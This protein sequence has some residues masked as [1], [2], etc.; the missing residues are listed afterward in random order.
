V[1][2]RSVYGATASVFWVYERWS[3]STPDATVT[4]R[5][6]AA[7][8]LAA[9]TP[10]FVHRVDTW[11]PDA[12]EADW[13]A[14]SD[15]ATWTAAAADVSRTS[16]AAQV[17]AGPAQQFVVSPAAARLAA[18]DPAQ[19]ADAVTAAVGD[20]LGMSVDDVTARLAV[21]A[22]LADLA[23]EAGVPDPVLLDRIRAAL[24]DPGDDVLAAAVA[25]RVARH[26]GPLDAA[27]LQVSPMAGGEATQVLALT[28]DRTAALLRTTPSD[29]MGRLSGGASLAS[30]AQAR[31]LSQGA[32]LDAVRWDLPPQT[33]AWDDRL[34]LAA[35]VAGDAASVTEVPPQPV[36]GQLFAVASEAGPSS[37]TVSLDATAALLGTTTDDLMAQLSAGE[38]LGGLADAAGVTHDDLVDAV[39]TDLPARTEGWSDAAELAEQVIGSASSATVVPEAGAGAAGGGGAAP[40]QGRRFVVDVGTGPQPVETTLDATLSVLGTTLPELAALLDAG[41]SLDAVAQAAGLTHGDLLDAL[42]ADLPGQTPGW[43]DVYALAEQVAVTRASEPLTPPAPEN[44]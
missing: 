20:P 11:S 8:A 28:L 36:A 4:G 37:L 24:P 34:A 22:S 21:G 23:A 29:L 13:A 42:V 40:T 33:P 43:D 19:V 5:V 26:A 14:W 25:D 7:T 15:R 2:P 6:N 12:V 39:L 32:L 18:L 27:T 9:G 1:D 41:M 10:D 31:G 35:Q 17:L 3:A 44:P 30:L 16:S 38:T